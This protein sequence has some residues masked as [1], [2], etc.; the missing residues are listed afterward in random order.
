MLDMM[1]AED[2]QLVLVIPT[3][4]YIHRPCSTKI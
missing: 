1:E 2:A 3:Y 4:T